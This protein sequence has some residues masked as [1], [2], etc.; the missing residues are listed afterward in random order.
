MNCFYF[1]DLIDQK[2][3]IIHVLYKIDLIDL[4]IL[5]YSNIFQGWL[6]LLLAVRNGMKL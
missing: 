4:I 3:I 5:N 2:N 1:N 6:I